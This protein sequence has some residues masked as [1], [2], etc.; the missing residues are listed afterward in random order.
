MNQTMTRE[1][2][3]AAIDGKLPPGRYYTDRAWRIVNGTVLG[4]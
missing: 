4:R 3:Q 1:M 2:V